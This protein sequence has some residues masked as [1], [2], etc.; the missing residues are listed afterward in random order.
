MA[1]TKT[2]LLKHDFP[3]HGLKGI[4]FG[5]S[6][7]ITLQNI[8]REPAREKDNLKWRIAWIPLLPCPNLLF[9]AF[10]DFLAFFLF[11]DFLAILSVFPSFPKDFRVR[12]AQEILA[13]LVLFLAVFQ[14]ARKRRSGW[15]PG[16]FGDSVEFVRTRG[17][18]GNFGKT[19]GNSVEFSGVL[20]AWRLVWIQWEFLRDFGATPDFRENLGWFRVL[21]GVKRL[22][23]K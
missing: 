18:S 5:G 6:L 20:F 21:W 16:N 12:Q 22:L 4:S 23:R 10:L 8:K 17:N 1:L 2:R 11:E 13:F 14:K 3:V 9:L 19:Q 7:K 15:F